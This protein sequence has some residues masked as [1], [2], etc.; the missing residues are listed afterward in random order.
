MRPTRKFTTSSFLNPSPNYCKP[1]SSHA[2]KRKRNEDLDLQAYAIPYDR[3]QKPVCP[4]LYKFLPTLNP[5]MPAIT[6]VI[7][8]LSIENSTKIS[9]CLKPKAGAPLP[10]ASSV[11][12]SFPSQEPH[13]SWLRT[14]A[15][16]V[17]V[18]NMQERGGTY[19]QTWLLFPSIRPPLSTPSPAFSS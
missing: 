3:F 11:G 18:P 6:K 15:L 8:L 10:Q 12:S 7:L 16:C 17:L 9:L 19:S 5:H 13:P 1:P 4:P 14:Q 2:P